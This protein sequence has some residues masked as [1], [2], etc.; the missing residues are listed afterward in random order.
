MKARLNL[1]RTVAAATLLTGVAPGLALAQDV[2]QPAASGPESDEIVVTARKREESKQDI[3]IS[4]TNFSAAD[5]EDRLILSTSDL[6]A[7]TPGFAFN[8]GFGRDGD[9]P[10]IRGTANILITDGKVG[11]FVDGAPILGDTSGIDLESFARVE[12]IKGPQSA[13]F[14]RGTLS[15]AINYVSRAPTDE[16]KFKIEGTMGN[17]GRADVF[18]SA[19]GPIPLPG[20]G[21]LLRGSITYK[22]YNFDGDYTNSLDTSKKLG[23]QNSTTVNAA[24]FF[25]PVDELQ[26]SLRYINSEDRDSHFAVRLL[27]GSAANCFLTT[28]PTFCGT[29]APPSTFAIN[30]ADILN[31]GLQR[32]T[33]RYIF[34]GDW[35]LFD[36]AMTASLQATSFEQSEVSGYDQSY[37]ERTFYISAGFAACAV[38]VAN[39]RCGFSNFNDTSGYRESGNTWEARLE[40]AP[41]QPIRWRIGYF[42][43]DRTRKNDFRWLELTSAGPDAAGSRSTTRTTAVFG[44]V[45]WDVTDALKVGFEVR[46][47]KDRIGDLA[48]GYRVGDYFPVAPTGTLSYNPNATVGNATAPERVRQFE[49]TLPRVTVDYRVSDDVL[50]YGQYS[51]GNAPGGFNTAGA[52]QE[53][54]DEERLTNFEFGVKTQ[55]FGFDYLNATVF[56]ME[57]DDQVLTTNFASTTAVQ[58]YN[59]NLGV[60]EIT[61]FEFEAQRSVFEGFTV[62]G[63]LSFVDGEF[64]KGTDPQQ[65]LFQG[66][67][68]CTTS[69]V[70]P[71][72]SLTGTTGSILPTTPAVTGSPDIPAN[73]SCATMGSIV[74]KKSPLVPPVQA[75]LATRYETTVG[76]STFFIG[77]DVV[78]RDSFFAQVDNLQSTGSATRVNAQV[79]VETGGWK[80]TLWGKNLTEEDT[81][82]GIL[83]YVDFLAPLPAS[84]GFRGTPRAFAIAAPRKAAYGVTVSVNW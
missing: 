46:R 34:S 54:F 25:S 16:A 45:E 78:Y 51:V 5:I 18:V 7:F 74:G 71:G 50:F 73:T 28:R 43:L 72:F 2:G 65:A 79:G 56:F 52:P 61:G 27:P 22:S 44:G 62:T 6:A 29:V 36:G 66:G 24:L 23:A 30:T 49:S 59:T 58:S 82:E 48:L 35:D 20:L 81:P 47:Q 63:T 37:D 13:V 67:G 68:Y 8:E 77:A 3:P 75:S 64:T 26:I 32:D 9:R 15:G 53:A 55:L 38:P 60:Q 19:A 17:W 70:S 84:P 41:D 31:P 40:S 11:T 57:Y 39:R 76:Q 21:D 42:Q 69:F 83:R 1:F 14:G 4:V 33:E 10:V 12:V 80:A